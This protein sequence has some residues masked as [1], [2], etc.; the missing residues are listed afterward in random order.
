M[1]EELLLTRGERTGQAILDAA[2]RLV[3]SQGYHGTSMRQIA[4]GAGIAV[5]GIYNHFDGK[6]AIFQA[7]LERHQPYSN[8]VA[9]LSDL[10]GESAAEL[11]ERAARLTTDVGLADPAFIRLVFIDLQEFG[12][13]T[14]FELAQQLVQG[15]MAFF[16]ALVA[17]GELREDLPLPVLVRFFAGLIVFYILSE[18]VAFGDGASRLDLPFPFRQEIDWVGGMVDLYLHGALKADG[19]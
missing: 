12:G 9:A 5:G 6:E 18:A 7:L 11:V 3:L 4:D 8:I 14:V 1:T 2:E 10:S 17:S 16:G 19:A 15:L 13:D